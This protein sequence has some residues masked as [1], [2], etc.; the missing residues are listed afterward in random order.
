MKSNRITHSHQPNRKP[1]ASNNQNKRIEHPK[2]DQDYKKPH[3]P[4]VTA[5]T[6]SKETCH[7]CKQ[8]GHFSR[9]CPK[10][11]NR[12]NNL[13]V[14]NVDDFSPGGGE[15]EVDNYEEEIN[16][17]KDPFDHSVDHMVLAIDN[18][19][20]SDPLLDYSLGIGAIECE[21]SEDFS[22]AEIQAEAHQPQN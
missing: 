21:I 2:P 7:F 4:N 9:E 17:T 14:D 12:I 19:G 18:D 20:T 3:Q 10:K 8:I 5:Q 6:K 15:G 13:D 22:I 16:S 11:R 1:W